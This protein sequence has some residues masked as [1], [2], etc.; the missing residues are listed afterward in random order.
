MKGFFATVLAVCQ[1]TAIFPE[2]IQRPLRRALG[3]LLLLAFLAAIVIVGCHYRTISDDLA[4]SAPILEKTFGAV[5]RRGRFNFTPTLDPDQG[6]GVSLPTSLPL[7]VYYLPDVETL[8]EMPQ[9]N[10]DNLA[11]GI[12]WQPQFI[13]F[14]HHPPDSDSYN[15]WTVS[16]TPAELLNL[17]QSM[18]RQADFQSSGAPLQRSWPELAASLKAGL[19]LLYFAVQFLSIVLLALLSIGLFALVF[20]LTGGR[21]TRSIQTK[22][23]IIL[24]IYAG[25]PAILVGTVFLAL[26]LWLLDYTTI[27]MFGMAIY[28]LFAMTCIERSRLP[29]QP[30]L[31]DHNDDFDF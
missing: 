3:H 12:L 13:L 30:Q 4:V 25:F 10:P 31:P 18:V 27:Y 15:F 1:G 17:L 14:W 5:Q 20:V 11:N 6:R 26:D 22:E 7:A 23:L 9:F 8:K 29:R 21:R 16:L 28:L 2:L 24:G 19:L